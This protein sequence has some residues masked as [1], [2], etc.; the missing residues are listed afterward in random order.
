MKRWKALKNRYTKERS[1]IKRAPSG[2]S[3][4]ANLSYWPLYPN[5]TF[6]D[7]FVTVRRNS[8][9]NDANNYVEYL[10]EEEEIEEV[11]CPVSGT[12]DILIFKFSITINS[13]WTI[14]IIRCLEISKIVNL[15][16]NS[17]FQE[18]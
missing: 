13:D 16:S 11:L 7:P 15:F 6:L 4:S 2:S 18:I 17:I 1:K 8:S 5:L 3:S 10:N 12:V 14:N 9:P